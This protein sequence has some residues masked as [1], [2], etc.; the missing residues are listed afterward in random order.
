M[1][2][3]KVG[4]NKMQHAT[5]FQNSCIWSQLFSQ[6]NNRNEILAFRLPVW[7]ISRRSC[8]FIF[9]IFC[10]Y[11]HFMYQVVPGQLINKLVLPT[12]RVTESRYTSVK[13][14]I[15]YRIIALSFLLGVCFAFEFPNLGKTNRVL[16]YFISFLYYSVS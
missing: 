14:F 10:N 12:S 13:M 11:S 9:L 15:T 16:I 8:Q 4:I 5:C 7:I 3:F 1:I 2:H 6:K